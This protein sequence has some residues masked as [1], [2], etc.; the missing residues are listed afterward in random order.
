MARTKKRGRETT[1][2]NNAKPEPKA[3]RAHHPP[4]E[5]CPANDEVFN[6][7][8]VEAEVGADTDWVVLAPALA[9]APAPADTS[10]VPTTYD[11]EAN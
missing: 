5:E 6:A 1:R 2:D 9:S 8:A 10:P 3:A 4:T 11:A 7:P